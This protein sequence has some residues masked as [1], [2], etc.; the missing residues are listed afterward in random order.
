MFWDFGSY[1]VKVFPSLWEA[2]RSRERQ[3]AAWELGY[4]PEVYSEVVKIKI[5][6]SVKLQMAEN[7]WTVGQL[8]RF[9]RNRC[10]NRLWWYGY[11]TEILHYDYQ[12]EWEDVEVMVDQI[13]KGCEV[14]DFPYYKSPNYH[15]EWVFE[16]SFDL[17]YGNIRGAD[18]G[19]PAMID[20]GDVSFGWVREDLELI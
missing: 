15:Q 12:G 18:D 4:G 1:G 7:P 11:D 3:H 20:F 6:R 14:G 10:A 13:R 2:Y 16:P 5:P 19:G 17:H 9:H 8:P